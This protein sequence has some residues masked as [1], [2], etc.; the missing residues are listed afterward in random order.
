MKRTEVPEMNS[1]EFKDWFGDSKVVNK[2][3]FPKVVHHGSLVKIDEFSFSISGKFKKDFSNNEEWENFVNKI[4]DEYG[5]T[6]LDEFWFSN[7]IEHSFLYGG[8]VNSVFLK[9]ENPL[10]INSAL[11]GEEGEIEHGG[12]GTYDN[13]NTY[14]GI[15]INNAKGEK[16][17]V[18]Y[19]VSDPTQIKS[20]GILEK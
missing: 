16:G 19:V 10:I 9:M 5:D 3:G 4:Q 15:I 11:K 8:V 17:L 1:K 13:R 20:A 14:D 18:Y 6:L 2:D 7:K 12:Y